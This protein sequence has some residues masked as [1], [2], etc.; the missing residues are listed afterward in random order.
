MI[1]ERDLET[2]LRRDAEVVHRVAQPGPDLHNRIMARATAA[3]S[4]VRRGSRPTNQLA[5]AAGLA[6]VVLGLAFAFNLL[7]QTRV[8]QLKAAGPARQGAAMAADPIR[9]QVLLF[10]GFGSDPA[11]PSAQTWTWD[12]GGWTLRHP[13]CSPPARVVASMTYDAARGVIVMFGGMDLDRGSGNEN[14]NDT[15]T[16]DGTNWTEMHPS[17]IPPATNGYTLTY[18]AARQV[19]VLLDQ[20]QTW[21]WDGRNW[22]RTIDPPPTKGPIAYDSASQQIIGLAPGS[23]GIETWAFDGRAWTQ[24]PSPAIPAVGSPGQLAQDPISGTLMG[25]SGTGQTWSFMGQMWT[26][27]NTNKALGPGG[28]MSYDPVRNLVLSFGGITADTGLPTNE[29]WAWDGHRWTLLSGRA[30]TPAPTTAPAPATAALSLGVSSGS[31]DWFIVRSM[32]SSGATQNVLVETRDGGKSWNRRLAFG[33]IYDGMSWDKSGQA[34]VLWTRD[35]EPT[36]ALTVYTTIDGGLHWTKRGPTEWAANQVFFNGLEGWALGRG[37]QTGFGAA[38]IYHT[39]NGGETWSTVGTLPQGRADSIAGVGETPLVFSDSQT[40]W[41]ATGKPGRSQDSGLLITKDGG[42]SWLPQAIPPPA[43]LN[44]ASLVLGY[45]VF[46]PDGDALLPAFAGLQKDANNFQTFRRYIYASSDGGLT[47]SNPRR[48]EAQHGIQPTGA[49]WQ[50]FYL[51][52]RNW[53]FTATDQQS[54]GEPVPQASP[55][56]ARSTDGG[57]NWAVFSS[58]TILQLRFTDST[59]GWALAITGPNNDNILLRTTDGGAHWQR[60]TISAR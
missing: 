1:T 55:A 14:L 28:T 12:G 24:L 15:W 51:D 32:A 50:N 37:L 25:L 48:L 35:F 13:A 52:S 34:G 33:G 10:G 5:L 59:R 42:K 7:H 11:K 22:S 16:W 44:G 4:V 40:G 60:V 54:A 46:L 30:P 41:F 21:L 8:A 45:P 26:P 36:Q 18:D 6:I 39:L 58:P 17:T 47:W 20:R 53:W 31:G 49:E 27:V 23:A 56:V 2:R 43:D 57:S 38:P 3:P 19:S 29:L 9:Q